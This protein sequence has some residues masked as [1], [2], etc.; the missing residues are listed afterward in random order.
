MPYGWKVSVLAKIFKIAW[1]TSVA[2]VLAASAAH[3][4]MRFVCAGDRAVHA[5]FS[6][7]A[8]V[9][10]A[11]AATLVALVALGYLLPDWNPWTE[12]IAMVVV[13]LWAI[14]LFAATATRKMMTPDR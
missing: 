10:D 4:S 2:L 6:A 7:S 9:T 8:H 13:A 14:L 11:A 5:M 12:G 1:A 3:L